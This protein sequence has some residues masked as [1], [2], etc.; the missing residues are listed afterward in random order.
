MNFISF[1]HC[2]L[3]F[4]QFIV[5][6]KNIGFRQSLR[7]YRKNYVESTYRA[8]T[9][10]LWPKRDCVALCHFGVKLSRRMTVPIHNQARMTESVATSRNQ[11]RRCRFAVQKVIVMHA[12]NMNSKTHKPLSLEPETSCYAD[13][14]SRD[15]SRC[16]ALRAD[17]TWKKKRIVETA[18]A[19][20]TV[21][22]ARSEQGLQK[23]TEQ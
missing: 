19:H 5:C 20:T 16:N 11:L 1:G 9:S 12:L 14:H 10:I 22:R 21:P 23:R 2:L 4:A 18:S 13:S 6:D 17:Y 3:I 8:P 15:C 7:L